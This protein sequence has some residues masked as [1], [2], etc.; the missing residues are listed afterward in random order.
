M[1]SDAVMGCRRVETVSVDTA[2]PLPMLAMY[3]ARGRRL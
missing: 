2:E 3:P 1:R